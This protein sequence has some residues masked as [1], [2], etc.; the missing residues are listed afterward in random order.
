M[1][2]L[3]YKEN[4]N[5]GDIRL[6][7]VLHLSPIYYLCDLKQIAEFLKVSFFIGKIGTMISALTT[8]WSKEGWRCSSLSKG[9]PS[10]HRAG[11]FFPAPY[12][13]G[14]VAHNFNAGTWETE[15]GVSEV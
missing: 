15:T 4:S 6:V 8:K 2:I 11:L 14:I 9:L 10:V 1:F 13:L 5:T 3:K 7:Q 12:K